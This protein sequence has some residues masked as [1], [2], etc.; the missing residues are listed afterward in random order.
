MSPED[1]LRKAAERLRK[2]AKKVNKWDDETLAWFSV[3]LPPDENNK[4]PAY[5]VQENTTTASG[6]EGSRVVADVVWSLGDAVY[7]ALM[8]PP[9]ALKLADLLDRCAEELHPF[10]GLL[11]EEM[12]DLAEQINK[13]WKKRARRGA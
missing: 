9:V 13:G 11:F 10:D 8:H 2:A 7:I 1:K 6:G 3:Y 5:W 4:R 12:C